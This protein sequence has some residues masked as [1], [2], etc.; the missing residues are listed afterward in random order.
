VY[1]R[2]SVSTPAVS[3]Y[4]SALGRRDGVLQTFEDL[5]E[6][7]RSATAEIQGIEELG[8]GRVLA[9]EDWRT[10]GRDGIGFTTRITDVYTV[11]RGLIVRVDGFLDKAE[12]L[13]P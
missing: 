3:G 2:S 10:R 12:A 5:G 1:P 8:E 6:T 9:V 7:W 11:E 13:E 4:D